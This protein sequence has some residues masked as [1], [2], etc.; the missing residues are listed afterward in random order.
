LCGCH[1]IFAVD[2]LRHSIEESSE[3]DLGQEIPE[4]VSSDWIFIFGLKPSRETD[5]LFEL[6]D[7]GVRKI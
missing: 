3:S 6:D 2:E 5:A 4:I 1:G 7:A